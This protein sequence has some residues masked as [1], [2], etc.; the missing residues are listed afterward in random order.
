MVRIAVMVAKK[1]RDWLEPP[2]WWKK[3]RPLRWA[4]IGL[5]GYGVY[6]WLDLGQQAVVALQKPHE[7]TASY[8][9]VVSN[10]VDLIEPLRSYSSVAD[11]EAV[12]KQGEYGWRKSEIRTAATPDHPPRNLDT[13]VVNGYQHLGV[14]GELTLDFFNDRLMEAA[15]IP[16]DPQ[17]YVQQL[18][19]QGIRASREENGR[20]ERIR[21]HQRLASNVELAITEVGR[22]IGTTPRII[23]QDLRLIAQRDEWDALY[24]VIAATR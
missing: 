21:G 18:R 15:F 8:T 12:L 2:E 24:G 9:A 1:K 14:A 4:V 13:L 5:L 22:N 19:R 17:A 7:A 16:S 11:V 20:A 6:S 23:W 3:F 10:P